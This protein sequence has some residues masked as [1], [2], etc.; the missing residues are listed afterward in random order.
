MF[1]CYINLYAFSFDAN[2]S[3]IRIVSKKPITQTFE[4]I[5]LKLDT[6]YKSIEDALKEIISDH[7]ICVI[8]NIKPILFDVSLIGTTININFVTT[9]PIDLKLANSYYRNVNG[10]ELQFDRFIQ[11]A[12]L[13][14]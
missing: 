9:T 2:N 4:P 11:K 8:S 5:S 10:T 14:V 1:D 7:L 13:Y 3:S 12:L 6:D